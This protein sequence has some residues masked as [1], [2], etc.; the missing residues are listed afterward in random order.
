L[1]ISLFNNGNNLTALI[2][3]TADLPPLPAAYGRQK[4]LPLNKA[5]VQ[6]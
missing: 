5:Q 4:Q 1:P 2:F 3:Q 6:K